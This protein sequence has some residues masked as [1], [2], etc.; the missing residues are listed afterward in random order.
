LLRDAA[1][2]F[3]VIAT[4]DVG[5]STDTT[6]FGTAVIW[7]V[8]SEPQNVA[9][10]NSAADVVVSWDAPAEIGGTGTSLSSYTVEF[11]QDDLTTF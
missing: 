4:N 1:V 8:P 3:Y 6:L 10:A 2:Q 5:P 9:T 7:T 11:K